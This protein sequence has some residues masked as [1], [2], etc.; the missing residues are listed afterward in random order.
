M[1]ADAADHGRTALVTGAGSG[2]G[3]AIVRALA[4][5]GWRIVLC[6]RSRARLDAVAAT[7]AVPTHVLPVD[8]TDAAAVATLPGALPAA[9]RPLSLLV[10][11]AG[12]DVGGRRAFEDAAAEA[13]A[14]I[15]EA[16]LVG[17]VRLTH[18]LVADM[19][20]GGGGDIVNIGSLS[21]LRP[22]PRMA[23]YVASKA[24]V[25]AFSDVLRAD[26]DRHGIR[27]IEV[28]P[29]LT[30]TDFAQTRLH[31][32]AESARQFYDRA[33]ATLT[34]D[35][36]AQAVIYAIGQPRHVVIAQLVLMPSGQW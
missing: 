36:V 30:R 26:L 33:P 31:G 11:C 6:G 17:L 20:G 14:G 28:M 22:A 1:S 3:A 5:G 16:N 32:D 19:I 9:F 29:G 25:H 15:L 18:A 12:H 2:I 23:A 24:G 35:D 7:L 4:G 13:W 27:V 10:N 34:A 21:A 8:L